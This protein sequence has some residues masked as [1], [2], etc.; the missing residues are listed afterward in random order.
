ASSLLLLMAKANGDPPAPLLTLHGH[1]RQVFAVRF[2]PDGKSIAT[3]SNDATAVLWD[4]STGKQLQRLIGHRGSLTC[5]SFHPNGGRLA[6]GGHD[7][8]VQ[9]WETATG[10]HLLTLPGHERFA[11]DVAFSPG[12]NQVA[13]GGMGGESVGEVAIWYPGTGKRALT[14][15]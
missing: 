3:A 7:G 14:L 12:G 15:R 6:T 9:L 8:T 11:F 1:S 10:R 13:S 5:L 4:S 2:S